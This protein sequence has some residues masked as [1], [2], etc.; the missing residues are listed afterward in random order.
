[1][2]VKSQFLDKLL[3]FSRSFPRDTSSRRRSSSPNRGKVASRRGFYM[4][5]GN[6]TLVLTRPS[7]NVPSFAFY[8]RCGDDAIA[9]GLA[10]N[11]GLC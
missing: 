10:S 4:N 6:L 5:W 9:T 2:T 3:T 7:A 8:S 1:M 11:C